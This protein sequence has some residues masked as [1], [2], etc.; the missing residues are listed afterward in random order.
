MWELTG[1]PDHDLGGWTMRAVTILGVA[2]LLPVV[3][4]GQ[5]EWGDEHGCA[6]AKMAIARLSGDPAFDPGAV[7]QRDERASDT[8]VLHY[9]LDITI[10][11]NSSLLGGSNTITVRSLVDNLLTFNFRLHSAFT[12][13]DVRVGGTAA[14]WARLDTA[15]VSVA[16]DRPYQTNEVFELYIGYAGNPPP[17]TAWG[18]VTFRTRS[19]QREV[20][21]LSEPWYGYTWRPTKDDL[22]DKSTADM[23]FTVPASMVVA[24]N[25]L[26]QGT[27]DVSPGRRRY[28]WK[29]DYPTD[30]YLYCFAAT[31]YAQFGSTWTYQGYSMPL[32]FFIYPEHN[33]AENQ[34]A[35]LQTNSMLTTFSDLFGLYPFVTEKYG[36]LE[37]GWSGGMEHQTLTSIFGSFSWMD[38]IAHELA[39]Q[40]WGDNVTCATWND[41]WLNE[42]FATYAEALWYEYQPGSTGESALHT[43]MAS[44]RPSNL[45]GTV[46]CGDISDVSRIFDYDLSYLKGAWVLHMLR[47]VV[48]D[49]AFFNILA[50]YRTTFGG[51]AATTEDFRHVVEVVTGRDLSWFFSEWVYGGGAPIYAYGSRQFVVDGTRYVELYMTQTQS[52]GVPTFTMPIDVT[53]ANSAGTQTH[54]VWNDA[55]AEHLLFATASPQSST[56]RL[57][58]KPWILRGNTTTIA[59]VEG[60]PKI[61]TM[62]PVP[63]ATMRPEA[64]P[65][66]EIVF[67]KDVV[68]D[69]TEFTLVGARHGPASA[70]FA[71]DNVRHAVTLTPSAPLLSD[72]Y[73]LT[74][75]DSIVGV[76]GGKKLDGELVKPDGPNPLPSGDGLPGGSA[77]AK[78]L[79]TVAGDLNCDGVVDANDISPFVAALSGRTNYE[80]MYPG[81]PLANG[82]CNGDGLVNYADINPFIHA[83]AASAQ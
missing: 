82:D 38:G 15:T 68:A 7:S 70:T 79:V 42:G 33:S 19:G 40:W 12:I 21:T 29:T 64:L 58:P 3:V 56:V 76:A 34:A 10:D 41:V 8:D 44:R 20:Y 17:S 45:S 51:R 65:A 22:T 28:R 46:Y 14:S 1:K 60:P 9:D 16:L 66:L 43:A 69:A 5:F 73:T 59:F 2:L 6:H 36:M 62:K 13:S 75:S 47:H 81:C 49:P 72:T 67:Q 23:W 54:T 52:T 27:D 61:V 74:V 71:Y 53:T 50:A 11:P 78:F 37:W 32:Q 83:L 30:D 55:R 35:W 77:V 4:C 18:G 26:L 31:N 63:G 80:A 48:G 24:S 57:D 39:H 25:G